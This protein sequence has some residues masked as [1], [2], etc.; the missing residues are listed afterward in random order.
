MGVSSFRLVRRSVGRPVRGVV[1]L[2]G[3][4]FYRGRV[5]VGVGALCGSYGLYGGREGVLAVS[6]RC[7][8]S[9]RSASP[10][11]IARLVRRFVCSSLVLSDGALAMSR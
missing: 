5:R 9:W 7:R 4:A 3:V 8:M 11:S 2:I 1:R 6:G 10:L